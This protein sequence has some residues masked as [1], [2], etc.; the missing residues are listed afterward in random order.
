MSALDEFRNGM[1]TYCRSADDEAR[2]LKDST[3]VVEKLRHFYARLSPD[4]QKLADQVLAEWHCHPTRQLAST[5]S[6]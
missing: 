4:E 2:S 1:N 3:Q 6:R 5:L